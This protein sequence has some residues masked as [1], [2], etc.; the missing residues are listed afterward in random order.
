MVSLSQRNGFAE[1][2][3]GCIANIL[4]W[5]TPKDAGRAGAVDPLFRAAAESDTVWNRMLP[6]DWQAI[7]A[8]SVTPLNFPSLKHLFLSL[9]DNPILI[10]GATKTFF[11]E[12]LSGKKCYL[13]SARELSI[14]WGNGDTPQYWNWISLPE[15]SRFPEVA[16]LRFVWWFNISGRMST[17]M[18]S[19]KT[20][21]AAYLVFKRTDRA[22]GFDDP[23]PR[24]SVVTTGGGGVHQQTVGLGLPVMEPNQQHQIVPPPQQH[25]SRPKQREDGWLEI[26]LGHFFN[27]GGE[28]DELQIRLLEVEAGTV[29]TGLIV[30]GIEIRPTKGW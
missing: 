23:P 7:I 25:A 12:K 1:L 27:E 17:S 3:E 22:Y 19:P 10:D 9:S 29:K 2:P 28:D 13:L 30:E 8:Q 11:L 5:T 4:S 14:T 21:Y 6:S 26:E 15:E 18:L 16:E 24:A 20:N